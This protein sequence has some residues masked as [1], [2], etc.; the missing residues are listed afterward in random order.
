MMLGD[1]AETQK[2]KQVNDTKR[3]KTIKNNIELCNRHKDLAVGAIFEKDKDFVSQPQSG[4]YFKVIFGTK[5]WDPGL[6]LNWNAN[7]V[8]IEG[9]SQLGSWNYFP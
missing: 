2:T 1:A 8:E 9:E 3:I 5:S 7:L 6:Q 4:F